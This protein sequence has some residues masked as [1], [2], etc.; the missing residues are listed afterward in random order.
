MA[1]NNRAFAVRHKIDRYEH[2]LEGT[3]DAAARQAIEELLDEAWDEL[4][5]VA[6]DTITDPLSDR[7]RRW[8][9]KAEEYR[10]TADITRNEVARQA[11]LRLAENYERLADR[12]DPIAEREKLTNPQPKL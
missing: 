1:A 3:T 8:R 4:A 7:S 11:Y 6:N 10:M 5:A 2:L 12:P 9:L